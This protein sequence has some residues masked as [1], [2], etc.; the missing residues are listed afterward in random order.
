MLATL[1]GK[2]KLTEDK[3]A[4]V[5]VNSLIQSVS[6][7][8]G[9]VVDSIVSDPEFVRQ[10]V[11]NK[12]EFDKFLMIVLCGNLSYLSRYFSA[13]EEII[14]KGKIITKMAK[15][16]G[17]TYDQMNRIVKDYSD[18]IHQKNYPSKNVLY[19]MSK[20]VFYKY[21]LGQYQDAY[22]AQLDAPNP[23][24]LKRMDGIMENYLWDWNSFLDKYRFTPVEGHY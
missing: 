21:H 5:F 17:L 4:N 23:I 19:G 14:L 13:S 2:K 3:L 15:V 11:M 6:D 10:P 20:A 12:E 22:F 24:F 1:F 7:S 8:Y 16:Y 18:F 9:D